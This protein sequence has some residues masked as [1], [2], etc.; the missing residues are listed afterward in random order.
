MLR[1]YFVIVFLVYFLLA[2]A[3]EVKEEVSQASFPV[4]SYNSE[5][6][7]TLTLDKDDILIDSPVEIFFW[8]QHFQNPQNNL[9]NLISKANFSNQVLLTFFLPSIKRDEPTLITIVL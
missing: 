9:N 4:L 3:K 5:I 1:I 7:E 8:T 6:S 2:C